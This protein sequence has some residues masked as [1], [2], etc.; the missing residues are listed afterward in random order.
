MSGN[1]IRNTE[2]LRA[3]AEQRQLETVSKV[4]EAIQ[5]LIKA[6]A[7]INFNSVSAEA[8]VSKAYLYKNADVR[9]RVDMLR[10]QQEGLPSPGQVKRE[11]SGNSKDVLI[12][13]IRQKIKR[14]EEENEQLK[15]ESERLR[16]R[17]YE[18]Y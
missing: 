12:A 3:F 1:H 10:K 8:G 14:L 11:M 13:A 7:K 9:T 16:G 15:Q 5:R 17:L 6:K 4:D 18:Q 2:G